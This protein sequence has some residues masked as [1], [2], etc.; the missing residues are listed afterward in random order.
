M[1]FCQIFRACFQNHEV[2]ITLY[3]SSPN[4]SSHLSLLPLSHSLSRPTD[5]PSFPNS[6]HIQLSGH[7]PSHL[8][9]SCHSP[10]PSHTPSKPKIPVSQLLLSQ[11]TRNPRTAR[12]PVSIVT[13]SR[14]MTRGSYRKRD[15]ALLYTTR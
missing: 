13:M 5:L 10:S 11:T 9:A 15:T 4:P 7:S 14:Y 8:T 1:R 3:N 2:T 6:H 12:F